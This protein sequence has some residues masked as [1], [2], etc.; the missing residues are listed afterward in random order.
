MRIPQ[1]FLIVWVVLSLVF[2]V[3]GS[4]LSY[5]QSRQRTRDLSE[6]G[7]LDDDVDVVAVGELLLGLKEPESPNNDTGVVFEPTATPLPATATATPEPTSSE[8]TATLDP[9]ASVEPATP[10]LEPTAPAEPT[11]QY[12]LPTDPSRVTVLVMG[13]DQREGEVGPFNTD[14][15]IVLSIDPVGKTAAI[16]SIPRDLYINYPGI[17]EQRINAANRIGEERQYPGG[18]AEFAKRTVGRVLGIEVDYYMMVNFDSFLTLIEVIGDVEV[19]PP[20]VIDDPKYPD[21]SYGYKPVHFDPGCQNLPADRLL[22]YARTRATEGGDFDRAKRQQ[23]VILAVRNKVLS[24]GGVL[25]VVS[26]P[27]TLWD[28]MSDN[29]RTDIN[30]NDMVSLALLAETIPSENIRQGQIG[31]GEVL[32]QTT[33]NGE[34]VLVPISGD[35]SELITDL[36]R[37]AWQESTYESQ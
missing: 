19:C 23:E 1:W 34:E 9:A 15:M 32:T 12:Q 31:Q 13:I 11:Q 37:P 33:V 3:A 35:I 16:L 25:D 36:F 29:V 20:T 26:N 7:L 21:G 24:A 30:L 6:V 14:T 5:T 28:A 4:Y 17:G 2:S 8:P 18:G 22:E 10:T 27:V